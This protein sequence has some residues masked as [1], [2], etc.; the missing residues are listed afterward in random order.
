MTEKGPENL[1]NGIKEID[2]LDTKL[3][4]SGFK[5][6]EVDGEPE[7]LTLKRARKLIKSINFQIKEI[8]KGLKLLKGGD[9]EDIEIVLG[10]ISDLEKIRE[11]IKREADN[12]IS[13]NREMKS[14]KI[15]ED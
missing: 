15:N 4:W 2:E 8:E 7:E 6:E 12:Q 3:E 9:K 11:N 14:G 5:L 10:E 13:R 1:E